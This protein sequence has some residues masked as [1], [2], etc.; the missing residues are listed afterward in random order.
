MSVQDQNEGTTTSTAS[1]TY[2]TKDVCSFANEAAPKTRKPYTITKQREKWTEEEHERFLEAIKLYGR[3]WRQIEEHVGTKT[4]VQI[5]SHAQKFFSKV[6]RGLDG[7]PDASVSAVEIPPPRPKRKPIHPYPRKYLDAKGT[8]CSYQSEGSH[9]PI[10]SS[11]DKETGSP[12]SVFSS[13]YSEGQGQQQSGSCSPTS[14]T[15]DQP[16]ISIMAA[17]K[18]S[19]AHVDDGF[20]DRYLRSTRRK[21]PSTVCDSKPKNSLPD[22]IGSTNASLTAIKLFGR[23]VMITQL[24][25]PMPRDT[26]RGKENLTIEDHHNKLDEDESSPLN[27]NQDIQLSLGK[28]YS[29]PIPLGSVQSSHNGSSQHWPQCQ[30]PPFIYLAPC[31]S[32]PGQGATTG[33]CTNGGQSLERSVVDGNKHFES[34][35]GQRGFMPYKRC[36]SENEVKSTENTSPSSQQ[37]QIARVC[38]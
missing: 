12:S 18:L 5:R 2:Q 33:I 7:N 3:G 6:T 20:G 34:R 26:C 9:S 31:N 36:A 29:V 13:I 17:E 8:S 15:T 24:E 38:L 32:P 28:I 22:A 4:A 30:Y 25:K 11:L 10:L 1:N 35:K 23:T 21:L 19:K 14:C 27:E 37:A 16:R